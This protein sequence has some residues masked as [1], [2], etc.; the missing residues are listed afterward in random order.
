M[1]RWVWYLYTWSEVIFVKQSLDKNVWLYVEIVVV[2]GYLNWTKSNIIL[3]QTQIMIQ[4][5]KCDRLR[6]TVDFAALLMS[7]PGGAHSNISM[8]VFINPANHISRLVSSN[9]IA[10]YSSKWQII[11]MGIATIFAIYNINIIMDY[12]F[13]W[14]K[15]KWRRYSSMCDKLWFVL[16]ALSFRSTVL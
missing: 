4:I 1:S 2:Q 15:D 16:L 5:E 10:L 11:N 9:C 6:I 7:R 3:G 12:H 14:G 8:K 13:S